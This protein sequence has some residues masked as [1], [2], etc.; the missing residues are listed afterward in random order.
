MATRL[1]SSRQKVSQPMTADGHENQIEEKRQSRVPQSEGAREPFM[2]WI[3]CRGNAD[4]KLDVQFLTCA[5]R[6]GR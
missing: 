6:G 5:F 1:R 4:S 3:L 2:R